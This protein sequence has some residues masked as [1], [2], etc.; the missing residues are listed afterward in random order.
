MKMTFVITDERCPSWN[1]YY[2]GKHWAQRK[3]EVDRIH[4]L[5]RSLI[6]PIT[7]EMFRVPVHIT[8]TAHY[9]SKPVDPDN[10]CAKPYIDALK[11]WIIADDT[12]HY[13]KSVTTKSC[14]SNQNRVEIDV[15]A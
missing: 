10:V 9:K 13:V 6:D 15:E 8:I 1:S 4:L 7:V 14:L 5:V 2:S 11:G 3:A 12:L